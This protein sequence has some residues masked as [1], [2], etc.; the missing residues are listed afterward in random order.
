MHHN[1][2]HPFISSGCQS[3]IRCS[4]SRHLLPM[5]EL[6]NLVRPKVSMRITYMRRWWVIVL[7]LCGCT[8]IWYIFSPQQTDQLPPAVPVML[9]RLLVQS[10]DFP[11]DIVTAPAPVS[12]QPRNDVAAFQS[13]TQW[14]DTSPPGTGQGWV[15]VSRYTTVHDLQNAYREHTSIDLT[16]RILGVPHYPIEG[17]GEQSMLIGPGSL[18]AVQIAFAR[19]GALAYMLFEVAPSY[20]TSVDRDRL[21]LYA[22]RLDTRLQKEICQ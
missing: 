11:N 15:S 16:S 2:I 4:R 5:I 3:S 19:C 8:L 18:G 12:F 21:I 10:G 1:A 22:K 17:L 20:I 14:L 7:L 9:E 13:A 6:H